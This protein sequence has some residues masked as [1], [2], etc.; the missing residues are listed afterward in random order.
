MS[1]FLLYTLYPMLSAYH[2]AKYDPTLAVDGFSSAPPVVA[3]AWSV[4][5]GKA[6]AWALWR[7]SSATGADFELP[8]RWRAVRL[9]VA[10]CGR[11][12]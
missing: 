12:M 8:T 5:A 11:K 2:S 4:V 1:A 3:T 10:G 7:P 6:T 9:R